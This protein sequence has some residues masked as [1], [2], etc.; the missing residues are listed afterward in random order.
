MNPSPGHMG[1]SGPQET[2]ALGQVMGHSLGSSP[3]P[4]LTLQ[5]GT[6]HHMPSQGM[7]TVGVLSPPGNASM[8]QP[9]HQ[10]GMTLMAEQQSQ[11]PQF[12][13]PAPLPSLPP[14]VK[15]GNPFDF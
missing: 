4:A 15:E 6:Q 13:P 7:Q 12:P 10:D 1:Q 5:S 14:V 2:T 11:P 8:A 3:N 9:Y